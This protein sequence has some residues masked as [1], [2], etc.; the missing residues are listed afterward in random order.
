[1]GSEDVKLLNFWVS[2]FGKRVEWALKLK[3]VEY[4]YIEEDIFNKSNL[5]LELNP[6]H[7]KVPVLVHAQKPIAESFIILEYIDETWK[8]YPLLPHNP[9]QRALARFWATCVE[10]KLGKAGWVAMSTSGDEQEEAMKEAKEMME[11]IEEEI[12]GKNFFGGDNIGYLDIAIGWIAYLVP[13]WEEVGSM[14]IIDPLKFPATF[15]WMTNFLS[16]PVIKD[17]LPPRD[18]MLVYYHNRKNN[19]PSVFRNLVKD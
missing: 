10:Q 3:G 12:K 16:H 7:K 11:K 4:E 9:Y 19:L 5:L 17:S 15:A 18:K 2:P 13:V 14:Q 6:V 1:M 8:K